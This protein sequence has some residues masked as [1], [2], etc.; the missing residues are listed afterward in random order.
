[1]EHRKDMPVDWKVIQIKYALGMRNGN[2]E[3]RITGNERDALIAK[4]KQIVSETLAH[5]TMVGK[6]TVLR[7][8][9]GFEGFEREYKGDVP[10]ELT[11][12][13]LIDEYL[14]LLKEM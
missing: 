12:A 5:S 9:I 1:M 8:V 14:K 10:V 11:D 7:S 2:G 4:L 13:V 3:L 6:I